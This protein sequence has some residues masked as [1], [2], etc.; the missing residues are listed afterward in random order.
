MS[1]PIADRY[2]PVLALRVHLEDEQQVVFDEG[3]EEEA[4]EKQR[5][6]ELTAFFRL[7][8]KLEQS[9]DLEENYLPSYI[10]LPKKYRYDKSK[11]EWIQRKAHSEDT[12]IGRIHSVN[13][14][15]GD[16]FYLRILLHNEHCRGKKKFFRSEN[17]TQWKG[18]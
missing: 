6:T 9:E 16:V 3:N 10:E 8:E 1:F 2:P 18:V 17:V 14:I 13:P 7:N 15:A 5:D 11:K 4:L 12:V